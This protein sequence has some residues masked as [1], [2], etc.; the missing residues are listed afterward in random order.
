MLIKK[1][2][3][4]EISPGKWRV[5]SEKGKNLG[6]C[7]S[8]KEAKKRLKQ[9]EY[10]KH[11]AV[12]NLYNKIVFGKND[13]EII[14]TFS[15]QMRELRK[16]NPEKVLN[17]LKQFNKSFQNALKENVENPESAALLEVNFESK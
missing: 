12:E 6:T 3:I 16:K 5:F 14:N 13:P 8:K 10:F 1:A 2:Y 7:S 15:A 9:V 17:F 11:K 4:K